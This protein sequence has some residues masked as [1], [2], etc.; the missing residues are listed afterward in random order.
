MSII[1]D[2]NKGKYD[3]KNILKEKNKIIK[4]LNLKMN[5]ISKIDLFEYLRYLD[6]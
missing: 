1:N 6:K 2:E 4:D 3:S 5:K